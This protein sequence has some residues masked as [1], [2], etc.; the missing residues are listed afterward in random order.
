MFFIVCRH[1]LFYAKPPS[2]AAARSDL[3]G[4]VVNLH[5]GSDKLH[6]IL[7]TAVNYRFGKSR[8][9]TQLAVVSASNM[10]RLPCR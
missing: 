1:P 6:F 5:E 7:N 4:D 9:N 3:E 10:F 8:R 2:A